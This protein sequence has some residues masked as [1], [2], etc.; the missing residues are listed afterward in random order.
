[1]ALRKV[2]EGEP[3]E[4][5]ARFHNATVDAI[6]AVRG[7]QSSGVVAPRFGYWQSG[8]VNVRNDSGTD[9]DQFDVLAISG[10][11]FD[12]TVD[13]DSFKSEG[14]LFKGVKPSID[15]FTDHGM[16]GRFGVLMEPVASGEIASLAVD[17]VVRCQVNMDA[18]W[19]FRADIQDDN[20][21]LKSYP[22][23]SCQ[24]LSV[25]RSGTGLKWAV[26]RLG[27]NP[28]V[29]Y[30]CV[31]DAQLNSGSSAAASLYFGATD[32]T[33]TVTVY[34]PAGLSSGN[35]ASGKKLRVSWNPQRFRLEPDWAAEC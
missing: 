33:E 22:G 6:R 27:V 7:M 31:L 18:T 28:Y 19:H 1:M 25:D 23:G 32:T 12:P 9:R 34:A 15:S 5:S 24:I 30:E 29:A 2:S 14:V 10:L 26:V 35:I 17:G 3:F 21:V 16:D 4:P 11:V 13:L 20:T 8:I